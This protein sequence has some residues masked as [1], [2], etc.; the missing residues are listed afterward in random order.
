MLYKFKYIGNNLVECVNVN[1]SEV[2]L[3]TI[4]EAKQLG[5]E[6]F[7]Y[8]GEP[9]SVYAFAKLIGRTP[10]TVECA[11][12]R[13]HY[14]TGEQ[15]IEHYSHSRRKC[16]YNNIDTEKLEKILNRKRENILYVIRKYN[17]TSEQEVIDFY[18][19]ID[20][21]SCSNFT[22][23]GERI[24]IN[25]FAPIVNRGACQVANVVRQF[26]YTTGEQIIEHYNNI[27]V[28]R[29]Y[30]SIDI[31]LL[32]KMFNKKE[33][34]IESTIRKHNF[35]T[36]QEVINFYNNI[37]SKT[38]NNLTYNGK[39]IT[40]NEL[41]DLLGKHKTA[42]HRIIKQNNYSAGEQVINHY[43]L[44]LQNMLKKRKDITYN[45]VEMSIKEFA[46]TIGKNAHTISS[47][48]SKHGFTTGEQIVE[49]YKKKGLL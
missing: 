43:R 1:N 42:I 36:E 30:S 49:H 17:F 10:G 2:L 37:E 13:N 28:E 3:L 12:R 24:S 16:N 33:R 19:S 8:K 25:K 7:T 9:I 22:Y 11:I 38:V 23:K 44:R 6:P 5:Y 41:A 40:V 32:A 29:D 35:T 26:G 48:K 31:K 15:V 20:A 39:R 34:S 18:N 14:I 47:I 45:G 27:K 21:K 46:E 4:D